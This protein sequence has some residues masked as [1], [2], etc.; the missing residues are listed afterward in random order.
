MLFSP[1]SRPIARALGQPRRCARVL[2]TLPNNP[3]VYV[4]TDPLTSTHTLTLT[5]TT[6]PVKS[7]ALGTASSIP[8]TPNS[9]RENPAFRGILQSVLAAHAVHD[10][11]VQS[12]AA[13]YASQAGSMLGGGGVVFPSN[14]PSQQQQQKQAGK[15]SRP[16]SGPGSVGGGTASK[17][18]SHSASTGGAGGASA[19]GGSGGA[20][21]GGWVHVS[22]QRNPPDYGRI[23]WPEDMFGSVEVDG[24]GHFVDGAGNYQESGTYRMCTNEGFLGL[25]PYLREKVVERLEVLEKQERGE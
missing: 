9:F 12:Q 7:L 17:A 16:S 8:P 24:R 18:A 10:P 22:D 6:P 11:A 23:A 13:A 21:R 15:R 20:G 14:H 19:Q 4:H 2:S 25:S 1:S 3:H 5:P